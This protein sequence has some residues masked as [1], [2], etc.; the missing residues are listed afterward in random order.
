M[1]SI[2]SIKDSFPYSIIPKFRGW[3]DFDAISGVHMK[4]KLNVTSI[5]NNLGGRSHSPVW[6]IYNFNRTHSR[7]NINLGPKTALPS[8]TISLQMSEMDR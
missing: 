2:K 3:P 8:D 5:H 1:T 7:A 4:L 6:H